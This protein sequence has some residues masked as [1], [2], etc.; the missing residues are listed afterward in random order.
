MR[1]K[2]LYNN[3]NICENLQLNAIGNYS[4]MKCIW[5]MDDVLKQN[6][7]S[8]ESLAIFDKFLY[9]LKYVAVDIVIIQGTSIKKYI[10]S[11]WDS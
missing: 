10:N 4:M 6:Q 2:K 8:L 9:C 1:K 7:S 11:N 5:W 3:K